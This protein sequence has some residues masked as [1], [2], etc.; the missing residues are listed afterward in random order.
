MFL[1]IRVIVAVRQVC[2]TTIS[3]SVPCLF[4]VLNSNNSSLIFTLN[5][6]ILNKN[7]LFL[8]K[9]KRKTCEKNWTTNGLFLKAYHGL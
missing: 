2:P 8:R 7:N 9:I 6:G 1:D 4:D 3:A 5:L